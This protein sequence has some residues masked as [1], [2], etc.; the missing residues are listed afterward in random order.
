MA[1]STSTHTNVVHVEVERSKA[2]RVQYWRAIYGVGSVTH[3][4]LVS[5]NQNESFAGV[6]SRCQQNHKS[7]PTDIKGK[8]TT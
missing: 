3:R 7:A 4:L 6:I 1:T 5:S 8:N 2:T